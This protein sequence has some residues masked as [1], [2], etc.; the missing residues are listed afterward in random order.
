M[1]HLLLSG[2]L[3]KVPSFTTVVG[4]VRTFHLALVYSF[5]FRASLYATFIVVSGYLNIYKLIE[6]QI[7]SEGLF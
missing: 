5:S 3:L 6:A 7:Q 2:S 1:W 4:K